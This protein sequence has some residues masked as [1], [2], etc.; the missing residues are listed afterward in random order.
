LFNDAEESGFCLAHF[1]NDGVQLSENTA[2][3]EF[4]GVGDFE[5]FQCNLDREGFKSCKTIS[6]LTSC[7]HL[8]APSSVSMK[9][10][11]LFFF[12]KFS[13][14]AHEKI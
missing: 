14:D 11:G 2:T 3:I 5:T 9:L 12:I 13:L 7:H 8:Q 4:T 1:I 6:N 10:M